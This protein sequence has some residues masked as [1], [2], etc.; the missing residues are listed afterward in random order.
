[1]SRQ[2]AIVLLGHGSRRSRGNAGV[3]KLGERLKAQAGCPVSVGFI[4]LAA[5]TGMEAIDAAVKTGADEVV[6]TPA[7]LLAAGHA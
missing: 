7:V 2:R 3:F 1:V 5:P 6:V 4:E